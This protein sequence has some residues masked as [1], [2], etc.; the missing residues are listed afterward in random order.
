[1]L[2][3]RQLV[4]ESKWQEPVIVI[5]LVVVL[6][7]VC[8]IRYSLQRLKQL[9]MLYFVIE[10]PPLPPQP[11]TVSSEFAVAADDAVTRDDDGH[12]IV[13]IRAGDCA[14]GGVAAHAAGLLPVAA[15]GAVWNRE[16]LAPDTF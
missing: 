5:V 4:E 9:C 3:L 6:V 16:Q 11:A 15:G 7:L 13:A 1:M 12:A 10:Q 2:A 8:L 14:H